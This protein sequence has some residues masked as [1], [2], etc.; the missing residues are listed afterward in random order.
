MNQIMT[1]VPLEPGDDE[2]VTHFQF[3]EVGRLILETLH[4]QIIIDIRH[5]DV[6]AFTT[7]KGRVDHLL[8][9]PK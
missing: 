4:G 1:E 8:I 5:N 9:A 3:N 7:H 2:D 6:N